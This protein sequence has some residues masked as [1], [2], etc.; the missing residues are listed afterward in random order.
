M[1]A[2]LRRAGYDS[3]ALLLSRYPELAIFRK[4]GR[5]SMKCILY[6]QA[7]IIHLEKELETLA[8]ANSLDPEKLPLT[9]DWYRFANAQ[10]PD[11]DICHQRAKVDELQTKLQQYRKFAALIHAEQVVDQIQRH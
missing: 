4:F 7:E 8:K 11:F 1:A 3:L 5:L 9:K 6:R 2:P 10:D